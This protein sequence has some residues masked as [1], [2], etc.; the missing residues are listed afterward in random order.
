MSYF[1]NPGQYNCETCGNTGCEYHKQRGVS[2]ATTDPYLN[3]MM[4]PAIFTKEKGCREWEPST[5][6]HGQ[7]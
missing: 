5:T 3:R 2:M 4:T 1:D 6:P 7:F